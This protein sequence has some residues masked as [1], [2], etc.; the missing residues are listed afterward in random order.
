M[1]QSSH[2]CCNLLLLVHGLIDWFACAWFVSVTLES[3]AENALLVQG[4]TFSATLLLFLQFLTKWP[5]L[6]WSWGGF[7]VSNLIAAH[8]APNI[9][10]RTHSDMFLPKILFVLQFLMN[11]RIRYVHFKILFYSLED[12]G[13]AVHNCKI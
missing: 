1:D 6:I 11:W 10:S 12:R 7:T 5:W 3:C 9:F 8:W 2:R 4:C 13:V